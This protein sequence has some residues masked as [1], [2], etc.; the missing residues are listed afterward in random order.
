MATLSESLAAALQHHQ[1]GRWQAAEEI[2]R[3]I[4]QV[5]PAH[6][7]ALHFLGVLAHQKGQ[8]Q[9]AIEHIG[10][11]I[12]SK[13]DDSVVHNN[14]GEAF[15]AAGK[16]PEA[17]DCYRRALEFQPDYAEAHNNLGNAFQEQR[18]F[19]V[20]I[21]SYRRALNVRPDYAKAHFNLGI[22]FREQDNSDEAI[23]CLR[24]A[25][26][27]KPDF[28]EARSNLGLLL[29]AQGDLSEALTCCRLALQINPGSAEAH[30]SLGLVLRTQGELEE[31]ANC[32]RRAL[33]I[34]PDYAEAHN[35]LADVSVELGSLPEAEAGFRRTLQLQPQFVPA[36]IGLAM[37]LRGDLPDQDLTALEN[38]LAQLPLGERVR[39]GLTFALAHVLDGRGDHARA[40]E[41][42]RQANSLRLKLARNRYDPTAYEQ[43]AARM[44]R[45]FNAR[46]FAH[47]AGMGSETRQPVFVFGL[48]RSGTTLI[49]QILASHSQICGAGELPLAQRSFEA[50][51]AALGRAGEPLNRAAQLDRAA[52]GCLADRH[53]DQLRAFD[54]RGVARVIDKMPENYLYLG[55]LAALFPRATFI[56]CRRD[57]RDVAVSCWM[58]DFQ[59]VPWANAPE[60]IADR[61]RQYR[62]LMEHWQGTLPLTIHEVGYEEAIADLEGVARRLI[63]ACGLEWEPA[64]LEF[65]RTARPVRTAS[66]GQVRRPL[67]RNSIGRWR[68]Y[69]SALAGMLA[70]LPSDAGA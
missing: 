58:T 45:A 17:I 50:L 37:L 33:Q 52:V 70:R 26:A 53:L 56:H 22:T 44:M 59:D 43:F 60:H 57:L 18:K 15:R 32:C 36:H 61:F 11:A 27:F 12:R 46:F 40:A 69:E 28:A 41:C 66:A 13:A 6:P 48:P 2:Y 25:L 16:L 4:L 67:Y 51:P 14:L 62:R 55:L 30:N 42:L 29:R 1:A 9:T 65:H 68:H 38:R 31:A 23:A 7:D 20:A 24:R 8:P 21:E 54:H 49:E 3:R 19:D 35:N 47:V 10:Q 63:S 64:C 5:D 39:A 34:Q